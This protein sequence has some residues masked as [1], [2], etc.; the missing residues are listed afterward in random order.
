MERILSI[1][2]F[3]GRKLTFKSF[4]SSFFSLRLILDQQLD[5]LDLLLKQTSTKNIGFAK[6]KYK[7]WFVNSVYIDRR[8]LES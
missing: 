5:Q 8:L 3:R 4:L 1:V 6:G 2:K 7:V